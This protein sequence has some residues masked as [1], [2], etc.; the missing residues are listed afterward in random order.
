[1]LHEMRWCAGCQDERGFEVPP[2]QDG[3][4]L[5]CLD[6]SCV[7]CGFAIVVGIQS[8][9]VVAERVAAA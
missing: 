7:D 2:C 5:D 3:H 4:G 9:I 1:M 8:E 6:L